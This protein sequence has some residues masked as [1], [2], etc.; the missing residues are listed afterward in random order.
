MQSLLKPTGWRKPLAVVAV[1][2]VVWSVIVTQ[3]WDRRAHRAAELAEREQTR[4]GGFGFVF[5]EEIRELVDTVR[6]FA[7]QVELRTYATRGDPAVMAALTR[8]AQHLMRIH[9]DFD[10]IR[11]IDRTGQEFLRVN[12]A[13]AVVPAVALQN[14]GDRDYFRRALALENGEVYLSRIDLN[15]EYGEVEWPLKP[16]VR[17]ALPLRWDGELFGVLVINARLQRVLDIIE[18][19]APGYAARVRILNMDGDWLVAADPNWEWGFQLPDRAG[20]RLS[21]LEPDT[22]AAM[23][24]KSTGT[25]MTDRLWA[26]TRVELGAN[27]TPGHGLRAVTGERSYYMVSEI[28]AAE[29]AELLGEDTERL[30]VTGLVLSLLATAVVLVLASRAEARRGEEEALREAAKAAEEGSRMKSQFLANI[31]HEIRTPMNGVIGMAD[32]LMESKLDEEQRSFARIIRSSGDTLLALLNDVLDFSKIEA[33]MLEIEYVGFDLRDPVETGLTLLAQQAHEKGLELT[34]FIEPDVP[35][36]VQ[37]DPARLQQVLTNLVSNAVKFTSAGEVVV[38][39]RV[40]RREGPQVWLEF[41]VRDTGIGM[42]RE[43]MEQLFQPFVQ[44]DASTTRRFGGTGLGLAISRELVERMGGKISVTSEEGVGTSFRFTV[45]LRELS[46]EVPRPDL[47]TTFA[48]NRVLVVDDNATNRD[49]FR[50]QLR[51]WSLDVEM[52]EGGKEAL[53][54]LTAAAEAGRPFQLVLLDMAMP[55]MSGEDVARAIRRDRRWDS[56]ALIIA[57]STAPLL[58]HTVLAELHVVASVQKPV[59]QSLLLDSV[60]RALAGKAPLIETEEPV[61]PGP[62]AS[63]RG[64]LNGEEI[65]VAE[66]NVTNQS[67]MS[68]QLAKLGARV[69]IAQNGREAVE[70]AREGQFRIIL[71]D[72]QM[73]V[74]DG[75]AATRAIRIEEEAS[76]RPPAYIVAVTA[77]A[78]KGDRELCEAA[79]MDDYLAK[80]VRARLLEEALRRALARFHGQGSATSSASPF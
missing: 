38:H 28:E 24:A 71:M 15:E 50:R 59:R 48:G 37:G 52:A 11:L 19:M 6:T 65:L 40:E 42:A 22:W 66:D 45:A 46:G 9:G 8:E 7:G 54:M 26:W 1:W 49:I 35:S 51:R 16:V 53:R 55:E 61:A 68:L 43:T 33:G 60:A 23:Q 18:T 57:S 44:A 76:G 77:D 75:R 56:T 70:I 67:V 12:H 80:P 2:V 36:Y 73:P 74:L 25:L 79:G 21:T 14:K 39:V 72:C 3:A 78:M 20:Q 29:W 34:Y 10:Q 64:F 62:G 30:I 63:S 5:G 69:R 32:L 13:G 47:P 27:P 17:A 31:S 41:S 58:S 4:V